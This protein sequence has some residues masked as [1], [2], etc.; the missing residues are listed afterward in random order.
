MI[1][2]QGA[3]CLD[4][5]TPLKKPG[6]F[7]GRIAMLCNRPP[8]GSDHRRSD[9]QRGPSTAAFSLESSV[10]HVMVDGVVAPARDHTECDAIVRACQEDGDS[11]SLRAGILQSPSA[12]RW[13]RSIYTACCPEMQLIP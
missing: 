2:S 11:R 13:P 9:L 8:P 1:R 7:G 4:L 3:A 10:L 5:G 6:P 12:S